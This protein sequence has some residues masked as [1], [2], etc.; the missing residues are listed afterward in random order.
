MCLPAEMK[1]KVGQLQR[2]E[3]PRKDDKKELV[4]KS[5]GDE[6]AVFVEELRERPGKLRFLLQ[7]NIAGVYYIAFIWKGESDIAFTKVVVEGDTPPNPKPPPNPDDNKPKPLPTAGRLKAYFIVESG[8]KNPV[9][10]KM[11]STPAVQEYWNGR[12]W[13][14]VVLAD[15]NTKDA[16]NPTQPPP[17]LKPYIDRSAGKGDQLYLVDPATGDVYYEGNAPQSAEAFLSIMRAVK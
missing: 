10:G 13:G 3:V 2:I 1:F 6:S 14:E 17:I 12:K 8:D 5:T 15:P 16:A 9:Y 7:G 4:Y 11:L